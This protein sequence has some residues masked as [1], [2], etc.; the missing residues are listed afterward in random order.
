MFVVPIKFT[1]FQ[2]DSTSILV[3]FDPYD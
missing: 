2:V 1:I 3:N